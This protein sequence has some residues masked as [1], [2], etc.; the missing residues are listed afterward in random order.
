MSQINKMQRLDEQQLPQV[1]AMISKAFH[2]YQLSTYIY[3]DETERTRR[4]SLMFSISL[5]YTFYYGEIIT[6]PDITGAACWLPP[7]STVVSNKRLLRIGALTLLLK[8]GLSGLYRLNQAETYMRSTHQRC[9]SE[10]HWYLWVLGV[11]PAHHGQGIGGM[12][13]RT[14]LERA[15]AFGLPSYLETMNPNNVSLYQKFGFAIASEGNIPGS[16]LRMWGM[17]RPG[18]PI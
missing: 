7:E 13:L 2:Q 12:L 5:C 18:K 17:V 3:P 9:I 10:P 15:D 6:T 4:L 11:D 16:N 8:M 1:I 14:G